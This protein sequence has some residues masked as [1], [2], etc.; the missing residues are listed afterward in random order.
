VSSPGALTDPCQIE[1]ARMLLR[2]AQQEFAARGRVPSISPLLSGVERDLLREKAAELAGPG[3][4]DAWVA[5]HLLALFPDCSRRRRRDVSRTRLARWR[6]SAWRASTT[7]VPWKLKVTDVLISAMS[8]VS[9]VVRV[10]RSGGGLP[11]MSW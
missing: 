7:T 10:L 1:A 4:E 2:W 8:D 5:V 11:R 3:T 6:R 9:R